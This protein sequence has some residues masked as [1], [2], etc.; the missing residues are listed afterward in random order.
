MEDKKDHT[1]NNKYEEYDEYTVALVDLTPTRGHK[2][3]LANPSFWTTLYPGAQ[4]AV[5]FRKYGLIAWHHGIY[6]G[7]GNVIDNNQHKGQPSIQQRTMQSFIDVGNID[8]SVVMLIEYENDNEKVQNLT[9]KLAHVLMNSSDNIQTELYNM[10]AMNCETF[11]TFC[12]TGKFRYELLHLIN[13]LLNVYID[14]ILI[15]SI[16]SSKTCNKGQNKLRRQFKT[17]D[18]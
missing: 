15:N 14:E 6:I 13:S 1:E 3:S 10:F 7:D 11:A 9:V 2:L 8:Q 16:S 5:A 17:L 12:R 18:S 4:I